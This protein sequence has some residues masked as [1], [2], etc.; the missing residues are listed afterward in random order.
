MSNYAWE[1]AW[2]VSTHMR[3]PNTRVQW[4]PLSIAK[5]LGLTRGE[6]ELALWYL[7]TDHE[8]ECTRAGRWFKVRQ[9]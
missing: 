7:R 5:K 8:V 2:K 3:T 1:I 4:T 9:P 6:V